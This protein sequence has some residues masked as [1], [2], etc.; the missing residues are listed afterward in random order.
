MPILPTVLADPEVVAAV[1]AERVLDAIRR[2]ADEG[3]A[4]VLGCPTG[5]TPAPVYRELATLCT[6]TRTDLDHLVVALMDDYVLPDG[7]GYRAVPED[8]SYSCVGY[9]QRV[10]LG[11]LIEAS[12]ATGAAA[13]RTL[14]HADPANPAT[15]DEQ[16]AD[17]GGIDL[18]LLASGASDGHVAFNPPGSDRGSTTRIVTLSDD[19]RRDNMTT[20]PDFRTLEQVPRHGLTVGISTIVDRSRELVMIV[21]GADKTTAFRR[22]TAA[23]R[24]EPDWPATAFVEGRRTSLYA[25]R[26]AAG[27]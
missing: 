19:T 3:R 22:L 6:R 27:L 8:R 15:Y 12:A 18:F 23:Q 4:F 11:P 1:V 17:A 24:Y 16:L 9:A 25:D 14:W 2:T 26:A 13:P 20:F 10:I 5:R 7:D 21:T